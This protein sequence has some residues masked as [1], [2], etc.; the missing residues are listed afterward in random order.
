MSA[1]M[2]D[3]RDFADEPRQPSLFDVLAPPSAR[4]GQDEVVEPEGAK[5]VEFPRRGEAP[6]AAAEAVVA[7]PYVEPVEVTEEAW[8][9]EIAP[10]VD[11]AE[12]VAFAPGAE[13]APETEVGAESVSPQVAD[14]AMAGPTLDDVMSRAWEGLVIGLPVACPVCHG[15][16]VPASGVH[17]GACS[18]CGTTI[19]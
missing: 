13:P 15:E 5:V 2:A 6:E 4:P 16:V 8:L 11:E 10:E 14:A 18:S 1:L 3:H 12:P 7:E 17:G 9:V 19:E